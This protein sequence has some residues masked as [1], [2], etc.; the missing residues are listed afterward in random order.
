MMNLLRILIQKKKV[1]DWSKTVQGI[2]LGSIFIG[3]II[4]QIIGG[5]LSIIFGPKFMIGFTLVL[6]SLL[7]LIS[8]LASDF[9]YIWLIFVRFLIGVL[10]VHENFILIDQ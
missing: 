2:V 10:Q 3:M 9:G 1:Y 6:A 8:P 7:T 4:S 5:W